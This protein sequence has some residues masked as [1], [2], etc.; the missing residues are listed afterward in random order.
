MATIHNLRSSLQRDDVKSQVFPW[1]QVYL[2]RWPEL[3]H[4]EDTW[5]SREWQAKGVD[6]VIHI[7]DRRIT[8][9]EKLRGRDFGDICLEYLSSQEK[10]VPGWVCDPKCEADFLAY[11]IEPTQHVTFIHFSLL[12]AAWA[13]HGANWI[14]KY[15][16]IKAHNIGKRGERYTT[17]SVG[18]PRMVLLRAI[19]EVNNGKQSD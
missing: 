8:V 17:L 4:I 3:T 10:N 15:Q 2:A 9:D 7:G 19:I 14:N 5:D 1:T 13:Q 6:R 16:N 18:V 12:R 11:G